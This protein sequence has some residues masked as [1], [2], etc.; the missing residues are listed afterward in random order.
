MVVHLEDHEEKVKVSFDPAF[1][2]WHD[3]E[4][5][6]RKRSKQKMTVR[7][8]SKYGIY[9]SR[10]AA[11][12]IKSVATK[13]DKH[14]LVQIGIAKKAIAF[15]PVRQGEKGFGFYTTKCGLICSCAS[16]V[17]KLEQ[18]L[19]LPVTLQATWDDENKMLVAKFP[20][21]DKRGR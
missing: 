12:R 13:Q 9:L 11:D 19:T 15:K 21:A 2:E 3:G 6:K 16:F 14:Y 10:E 1:F 4:G 5:M 17:S 18:V 8:M 7:I 20:S